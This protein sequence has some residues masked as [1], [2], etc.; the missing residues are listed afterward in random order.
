MK[1]SPTEVLVSIGLA[2]CA[3][4]IAYWI[5]VAAWTQPWLRIGQQIEDV[6]VIK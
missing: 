4:Y 3:V 1:H 5:G 2:F 6:A